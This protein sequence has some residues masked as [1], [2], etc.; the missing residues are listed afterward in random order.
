MLWEREQERESEATS[1]TGAP[2]EPYQHQAN[3]GGSPE[4][5]PLPVGGISRGEK[6]R[7]ERQE[8]SGIGVVL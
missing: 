5:A 3:K 6:I 4:E 7:A 1:P 2:T 8:E